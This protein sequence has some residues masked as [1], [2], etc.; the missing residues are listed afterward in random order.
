[1]VKQ[2]E[3][4]G[5]PEMSEG[6]GQWPVV[7]LG[8]RKAWAP[9]L[10]IWSPEKV[11]KEEQ[12][13]VAGGTQGEEGQPHPRYTQCPSQPSRESLQDPG[14]HGPVG[15]CGRASIGVSAGLGSEN[16]S[17]SFWPREHLHSLVCGPFLCFAIRVSLTLTCLHPSHKD[18][19]DYIGPTDDASSRPYLYSL[20]SIYKTLC[21]MKSPVHGC[22]GF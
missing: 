16:L 2:Q 15:G 19:D 22:Q 11:G 13:R 3:T 18:P 7:F 20:Y 12:G 1:M 5:S 14:M 10:L 17:C 6:T 4:K 8:L 21:H 9:C